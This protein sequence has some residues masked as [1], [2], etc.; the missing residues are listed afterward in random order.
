MDIKVGLKRRTLAAVGLASLAVALAAP[1]WLPSGGPGGVLAAAGGA[2]SAPEGPFAGNFTFLDPPVPAPSVGFAALEGDKVTL[3]DFR[4]KVVLVNFWATWCA[5]CVREMPDLESLHLKFA[6]E[7]FAVLAVSEDRGAAPVVEPFLG[8][9]G[10]RHLP[11]FL[12]PKG[13]LAR[14]F[15]VPGL[16]TSYLIDRRGRVVARL[17]GPAAW[18]SLEA[19]DFIRYYLD[20]NPGLKHT[21]G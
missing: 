15:E 7:G 9:L 6:E 13:S 2:P 21:S 3:A 11:V 18:D 1:L 12:D 8:E 19:E 16:P 14:A 17:V 5:P 4:G 10:L 20:R